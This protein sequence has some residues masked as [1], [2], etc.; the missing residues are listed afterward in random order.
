[1]IRRNRKPENQNQRPEPATLGVHVEFVPATL[2]VHNN[3]QQ[4]VYFGAQLTE[5]IALV[6]GTEQASTSGVTCPAF[7]NAL[8]WQE[9]LHAAPRSSGQGG[10]E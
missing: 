3:A 1:M 6:H 2:L 4:I 7:F 10:I 9:L 5:F 8:H